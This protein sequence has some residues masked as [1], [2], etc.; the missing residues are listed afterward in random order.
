MQKQ[1]EAQSD[2]QSLDL[3]TIGGNLL[4]AAVAELAIDAAVR[5]RVLLVARTIA[6]LDGR[7]QIEA[8][9]LCEAINYRGVR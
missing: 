9:H 7:E 1:I 3:D 6:N 8:C 2:Y 4:K 5:Q